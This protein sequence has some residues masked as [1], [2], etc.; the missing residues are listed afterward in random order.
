CYRMHEGGLYN[1]LSRLDKFRQSVHT[2]KMMRRSSYFN[3]LQHREISR[4]LRK[5][6]ILYIKI[7]L[8]KL[9]LV[10]WFRFMIFCLTA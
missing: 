2:R 1:R 5:R 10:S 3:K 7:L 8:K 9:Q 6:E 4:E